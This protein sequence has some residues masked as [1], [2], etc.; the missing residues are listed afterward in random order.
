[1]NDMW[2]S[3]L[4]G[5]VTGFV[6]DVCGHSGLFSWQRWAIFSVGMGAYLIGRAT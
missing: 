1:M 3:I 5:V 2:W 6:A 4:I